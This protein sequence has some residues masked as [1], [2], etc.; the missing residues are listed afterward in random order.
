MPAASQLSLVTVEEARTSVLAEV[1]ALPPE[2]V[3]IEHALGRVS[4][5][6][7]RAASPVPPFDAGA[8]VEIELLPETPL[9]G[10]SSR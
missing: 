4:A 7:V 9:G 1:E 10:V 2:S 8:R 3:P 5:E 6:E